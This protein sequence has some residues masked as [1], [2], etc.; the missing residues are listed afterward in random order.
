LSPALQLVADWQGALIACRIADT[1]LALR[2]AGAT[3]GAPA[4]PTPPKGCREVI[5]ADWIH[6][7]LARRMRHGQQTDAARQI[8]VRVMKTMAGVTLQLCCP[9]DCR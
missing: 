5:R 2:S 1:N 8:E 9:V 3:G 6:A 7:N 4:S